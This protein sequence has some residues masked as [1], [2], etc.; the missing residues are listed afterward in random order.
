MFIAPA[1]SAAIP[2]NPAAEIF[3][4]QDFFMSAD[5]DERNP[6]R[7]PFIHPFLSRQKTSFP[8]LSGTAILAALFLS[9]FQVGATR[10]LLF[11]LFCPL[12]FFRSKSHA[13]RPDPDPAASD[14]FRQGSGR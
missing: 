8:S 14:A 9:S 2:E 4:P 5:L 10:W 11:D 3:P 1:A 6:G 7:Q 12:L 13:F